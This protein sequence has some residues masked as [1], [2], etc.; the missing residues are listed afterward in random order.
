VKAL[1]LF[2]DSDARR[3]MPLG[4]NLVIDDSPEDLGDVIALLSDT[5]QAQGKI[6]QNAVNLVL[7]AAAHEEGIRYLPRA[8]KHMKINRPIMFLVGPE[9]H[10]S[11]LIELLTQGAD[12]VERA[13]I[14]GALLLAKASA[15]SR[16]HTKTDA[17]ALRAG[18][19][20]IDTRTATAHYLGTD[21]AKEISLTG[22]E[23]KILLTLMEAHGTVRSKEQ[24]LQ[25]MYTTDADGDTPE[26]KIVDVFICKVRKKIDAVSGIAQLGSH[27]IRTIWGQ[28]YGIDPDGAEMMNQQTG[29]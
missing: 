17:G 13:P 20:Y 25:A 9:V 8:L 14:S 21:G 12:M 19:L 22:K 15:L 18:P 6:E 2:C 4:H 24:I 28:G 23:Y 7:I 11:V 3:L 1:T 16:L 27:M 5:H 10:E 29:T 26:I